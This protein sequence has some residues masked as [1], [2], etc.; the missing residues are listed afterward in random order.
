ML[1]SFLNRLSEEFCPFVCREMSIFSM[2][3]KFKKLNFCNF[4]PHFPL[5]VRPRS[6]PIQRA[7]FAHDIPHQNSLHFPHLSSLLGCVLRSHVSQSFPLIFSPPQYASQ[8][9]CITKL[10]RFRPK[11]KP[12]RR[13]SSPRRAETGAFFEER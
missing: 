3:F 11:S 4:F 10:G 5:L 7:S 2:I 12:F 1:S 8:T 9:K 6:F 13:K